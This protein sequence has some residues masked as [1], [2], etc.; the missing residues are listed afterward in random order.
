M[1]LD[2][3]AR[4]AGVST[5][6]VSRVINDIGPVRP[7]TRQRVLRAIAALDYLPNVHARNLAGGRSRLIGMIVSNIEN[8][9]FLDLYH[10]L[11]AAARERDHEVFVASTGYSPRQLAATARQ[12]MARR[13][14]G[15]AVITSEADIGLVDALRRAKTP[16]VFFDL[17]CS[18]PGLSSIC[19]DYRA[20]MTR[21]VEY[22]RTLGHTRMAFVGHHSTLGPLGARES[23]FVAVMRASSPPLAYAVA[24]AD[25]SP[26]GGRRAARE[27]LGDRTRPTAILCANDFMAIGVLRE[28][29]DHG[30]AVPG[31]VSVTGFDN[32]GLS[33][34]TCPRL[35]TVDV[36]RERVGRTVVSLLAPDEGWRAT[37]GTRL[38][39]IPEL[40]V[41]ESTGRCAS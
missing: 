8:P 22:L 40:I 10:A 34:F 39:I 9:F 6:T 36:P 1:T 23:T 3:V 11:E 37:P 12:M 35:T 21:V 13:P 38:S 4:R 15:L 18:G 30:L 17:A 7:A 26:E 27:L 28:L 33:A 5:A 29:A 32:I 41:R 24:S 31:D 16:A 25:D 19:I 20:G 14:A 2:D